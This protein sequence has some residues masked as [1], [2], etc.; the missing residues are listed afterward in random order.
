MLFL[1]RINQDRPRRESARPAI[2]NT[3]RY[4]VETIFVFGM[5]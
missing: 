5:L 1:G 3:T 4:S 2:R